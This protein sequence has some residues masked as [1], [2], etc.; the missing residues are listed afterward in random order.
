MYLAS[1]TACCVPK[2]NDNITLY[3][4]G[5]IPIKDVNIQPWV[6]ISIQDLIPSPNYQNDPMT[7]TLKH[8]YLVPNST[9]DRK[10]TSH[11]TRRRDLHIIAISFEVVGN[12]EVHLLSQL[13]RLDL[14]L[15]TI[16]DEIQAKS[17]CYCFVSAIS[18]HLKRIILT[19]RNLLNEPTIFQSF[20]S[21]FQ[22]C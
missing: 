21:S 14:S 5:I 9:I 6:S 8:R 22:S 20:Y 3:Q 2:T 13:E 18:L 10:S 11:P 4:S 15:Q 16:I 1:T 12:W 19:S 7:P 17:R